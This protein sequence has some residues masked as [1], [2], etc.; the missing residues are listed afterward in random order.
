MDPAPSGGDGRRRGKKNRGKKSRNRRSG[1]GRS[2]RGNQRHN[3][4]KGY[5]PPEHGR[6][7]HSVLGGRTPD[8]GGTQLYTDGPPD[9]FQLFCAYYLGI[10]HD[11]GYREPRMEEVSRRFQMKPDELREELKKHSLDDQAM[12]DSGF[13][14]KGAKMDMRL[15]PE[16]IS[17]TES[18]R[19]LFE[20]YQESADSE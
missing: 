2:N 4:Q 5:K 18:A 1:K 6:D 17:R 9:A 19:D 20:E 13:D 8:T 16:G 10:T 12:R 7:D 15:A 11:D 3:Q 14:L